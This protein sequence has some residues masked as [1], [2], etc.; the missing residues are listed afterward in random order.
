[1]EERLA[2][3]KAYWEEIATRREAIHDKIEKLRADWSK[4]DAYLKKNE[5]KHA[6]SL[7]EE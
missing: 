5:G 3:W 4:L 7:R 1:M 2:K 6:E